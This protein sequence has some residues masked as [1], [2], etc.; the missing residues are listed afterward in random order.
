MLEAAGIP[1]M[2]SLEHYTKKVARILQI[3]LSF[4]SRPIKSLLHDWLRPLSMATY[5]PTWNSLLQITRLLNLH[6][7]AERAETCLKATTVD[8]QRKET[9]GKEGEKINNL[10]I[11]ILV[12]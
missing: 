10:Y 4:G 9:V 7:L 11:S 1:L 3:S 2:R 12:M 5:P 6:D 8:H